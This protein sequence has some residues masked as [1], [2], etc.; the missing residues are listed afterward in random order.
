MKGT[1]ALGARATRHAGR[2]FRL[3]KTWQNTKRLGK[4]PSLGPG[5]LPRGA[6]EYSCQYEMKET[7]RLHHEQFSGDK[8]CFNFLVGVNI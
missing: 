4:T 5:H 7:K 3:Q 2:Q 1:V 8:K 6:I